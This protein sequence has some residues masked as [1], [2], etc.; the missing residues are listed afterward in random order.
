MIAEEEI[1]NVFNGNGLVDIERIPC[2]RCVD[3]CRRVVAR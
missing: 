1:D 3:T 2:F